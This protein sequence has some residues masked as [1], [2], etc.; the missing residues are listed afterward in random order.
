MDDEYEKTFIDFDPND[1]VI[2]ISPIVDEEDNWTGELNVGYITMDDNFLKED[3]Y[4]HIDVVTNMALS[5]IP[6][7]E[8]DLKFRNQLY[9]YTTSVLEQQKKKNKP[10]VV[11]DDS[12][13]IQL[14]FGANT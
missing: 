1:F 5:S 11:K 6:L 9:K 12:N 2:R 4:M 10:E 3:D 7:M 8:D 13:V 14:R